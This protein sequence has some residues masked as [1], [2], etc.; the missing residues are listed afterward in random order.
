MTTRIHAILTKEELDES[1][2]NGKV[3]VVF[4]ILLATSTITAI[5]HAGA[6][7]VI[8]VKNKEEALQVYETD[9]Q[10]GVLVGE[11][12]GKTIEGFLEPNPTKLI[13]KVKN[14]TVILSTT[15][16]TVALVKSKASKRTYAASLLNSEAVAEDIAALYH[17]ETIILVC[18]GS[19]GRFCMEDFYGVGYFISCL[20]NSLTVDLT[21][22]ARAA[23]LFYQS[24]S[25]DSYHV[26]SQTRVGQFLIRYGFEEELHYIS[27]LSSMNSVP[28]FTNDS[29]VLKEDSHVRNSTKN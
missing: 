5:L 23:H 18:S 17:D 25:E 7:R 12:E 29:V 28:I 6:K 3:V 21:D 9:V 22:S 15:N 11:Y 14:K 26:L 13:N 16:G 27:R 10:D 4:D 1:Q 24:Y 20:Q 2:L 8:P 19:S